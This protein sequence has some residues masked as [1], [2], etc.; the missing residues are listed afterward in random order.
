MGV[1]LVVDKCELSYLTLFP[2]QLDQ[3]FGRGVIGRVERLDR[4]LRQRDLNG[5][6]EH[7]GE[8]IQ[9]RGVLIGSG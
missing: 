3:P 7:R 9:N 5:R 6:G 2:L 1:R 4:Q 8:S